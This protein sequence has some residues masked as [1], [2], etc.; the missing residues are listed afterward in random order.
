MKI[1]TRYECKN[2]GYFSEMKFCRRCGYYTPSAKVH[3]YISDLPEMSIQESISFTTVTYLE[4]ILPTV[5]DPQR[6]EDDDTE[7][8]IVLHMRYSE[9]VAACGGDP[10][11][12]AVIEKWEINPDEI[13]DLDAAHSHDT[14]TYAGKT[15][16][17]IAFFLHRIVNWIV[18]I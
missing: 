17:K 1:E 15:R 4:D 12:Q 14:H 6:L 10:E 9:L 2:C 8:Q 18:E 3:F 16:A 5:F 13:T 11:L 7:Y